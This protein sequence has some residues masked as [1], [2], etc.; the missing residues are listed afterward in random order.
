[1]ENA[2][3]RNGEAVA[4]EGNR[5]CTFRGDDDGTGAEDAQVVLAVDGECRE[6]GLHA[7]LL[8]EHQIVRP[9]AGGRLLEHRV[10]GDVGDHQGAGG[11]TVHTY[12][13]GGGGGVVQLIA[14]VDRGNGA[15]AADYRRGRHH[16]GGGGGGAIGRQIGGA[17]DGLHHVLRQKGDGSG[18][19]GAGRSRGAAAADGGGKAHGVVQ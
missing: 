16:E 19:R 4:G 2:I 7:G 3:E 1:M 5:E 8:G 10:G 14:V 15:I 9:I 13:D 11:G 17:D 6:R 12:C 18:G